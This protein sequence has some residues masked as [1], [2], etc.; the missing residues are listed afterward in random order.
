MSEE[1]KRAVKAEVQL[2]LDA[3]VIHPIKYP[4]WLSNMVLV[5]KKNGK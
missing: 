1:R 4:T 3:G 5:K 2:L